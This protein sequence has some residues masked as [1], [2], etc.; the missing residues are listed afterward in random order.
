[1]PA[2]E[3]EI[4]NGETGNAVERIVV[5]LPVAQRDSICIRRVKVPRSVSISGVAEAPSQAGE[6]LRGYRRAEEKNGSRFKS[7]FPAETIKKVWKNDKG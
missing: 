3:F 6:V 1:M 4:V 2:Y 5:V 7:E